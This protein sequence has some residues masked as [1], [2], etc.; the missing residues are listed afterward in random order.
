MDSGPQ[1]RNF[2]CTRSC[3]AEVGLFPGKSR[4]VPSPKPEP[5]GRG[6]GRAWMWYAGRS[7]H[8]G[9]GSPR[10]RAASGWVDL[11]Y[12]E[13]RRPEAD[14]RGGTVARSTTSI[15]SYVDSVSFGVTA[16]YESAPDLDVFTTGTGRGLAEPG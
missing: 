9:Q 10:V 16:D 1:D 12:R 3:V 7:P 11:D 4:R 13:P 14:P 5:C 2:L 8:I 15:L 6:A